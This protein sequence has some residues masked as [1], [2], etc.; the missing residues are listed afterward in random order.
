MAQIPMADRCNPFCMPSHGPSQ[1]AQTSCPKQKGKSIILT[2]TGWPLGLASERANLNTLGL[3]SHIAATVQNARASSK[4]FFYYWKWCVLEWWEGN[5]L[6]SYQCSLADILFF[7]QDLNHCGK[8]FSII[9]VYLSLHIMLM[10]LRWGKTSLFIDLWG[11]PTAPFQS[12][13]EQLKNGT[14]TLQLLGDVSL[15]LLSFKTALLLVFG[16]PCGDTDQHVSDLHT[17]SVHPLCTNYI[18][19]WSSFIANVKIVTVQ[20][21]KCRI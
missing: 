17:L 4:H 11:A 7:L 6:I 15:K 3:P 18:F 16:Q 12:L 2:W 9:K 8:S 5:K 20:C 10:P 1:Y 14:S 19:T 21:A 13:E